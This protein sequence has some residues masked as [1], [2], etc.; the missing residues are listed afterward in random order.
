MALEHGEWILHGR[1]WE[2]RRRVRTWQELIQRIDEL[3]FLPLFKNEVEGF[4]VEEETFDLFW[5]TGDREQDPWEWRVLI[6]RSGAVAYGKFFGQK[7]GFISRAWF[8]AFA[9]YRRDGFDFDARW[10]DGLANIRHKKI[11][12]CFAGQS[13][14]GSLLLKRQAGFGGAGEKNFSGMLTQ[15]QM[16]T[17]LVIR[18]FRQ[19][20][21]RN[22]REYGMPVSVYTRPEDLWSYEEVTAC[23]AEP[24]EQSRERV[25]AHVRSLYPAAAP[26]QLRR[27]LG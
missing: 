9:N 7:A 8:P 10:E 21:S 1:P 17:Y 14:W 4:S 6:A 11:M 2:D 19:K 13:E 18:D 27:V 22:G 16:Q 12:D 20:V 25:F 23:Y 26:E 3:G 24:P 15:L 5:W